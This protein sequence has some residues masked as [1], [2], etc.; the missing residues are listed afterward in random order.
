M[1]LSRDTKQEEELLVEE[2]L[3]EES[4]EIKDDKV[5]DPDLIDD[6]D[7]YGDDLLSEG[8]PPPMQKHSDLLK[9]L[10]DF[11]PYI[12]EA[13]NNWLGMTWDENQ[14]VYVDNPEVRKIMNMNG[15]IWCASL[16]KTYARGNNI[17]TDI[18]SDE[19]KNILAD[20]IEA[21]WLNLG[22]RDDLGINEDGDL[23]RVGNELEHSAALALMGAGD[24]KYNKFLGTTIT[25]SEQVRPGDDMMFRPGVGGR[26]GVQQKGGVLRQLRRVLTGK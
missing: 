22:T 17:I 15:A 23:I 8:G 9:S 19:Y 14:K 20:H 7:L 4:N 2:P 6:Y 1:I 5:D 25:R 3:I 12:K 18:S 26:G 10:T 11:N 16:M 21:I 24:G 13:I